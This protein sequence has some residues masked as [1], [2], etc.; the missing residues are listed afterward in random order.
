M[1]EVRT[2]KDDTDGQWRRAASGQAAKLILR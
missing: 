2:D 1:T